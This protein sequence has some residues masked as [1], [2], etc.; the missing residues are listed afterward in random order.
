MSGS[1]DLLH[2][3]L[4]RRLPPPPVHPSLRRNEPTNP[5]IEQSTASS[6]SFVSSSSATNTAN[7]PVE[8][9]HTRSPAL[10]IHDDDTDDRQSLIREEE[11]TE[12]ELR[13]IYDEEEIERFLNVF[14]DVRVMKVPSVYRY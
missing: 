1:G 3:S 4:T 8:T 14:T 9:T 5:H 10:G 11:L 7:R 2:P 6:T 13:Q 12:A